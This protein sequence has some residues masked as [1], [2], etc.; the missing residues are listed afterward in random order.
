MVSDAERVLEFLSRPQSQK[1]GPDQ[2][3]VLNERRRSALEKIDNAHVSYDDTSC[4]F[5]SI[6]LSPAGSM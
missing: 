6:H 4:L 1:N 2:V 5:S 3:T